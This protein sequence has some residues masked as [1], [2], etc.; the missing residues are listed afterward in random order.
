[1][2]IINA[3]DAKSLADTVYEN[4]NVDDV[5]ESIGSLVKCAADLGKYEVTVS[6]TE[7]K[8]VG[9]KRTKLLEKLQEFG[10]RIDVADFTYKIKISW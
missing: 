1:M 4:V 8:V 5:L 7:L 9:L 3:K 10:Y 6:L 2:S